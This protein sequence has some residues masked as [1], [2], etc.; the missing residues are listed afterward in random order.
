MYERNA[1]VIDRYFASIFGYDKNNNL[2]NNSSNYFEL[3]SSLEKYQK[4]SE[5][6]NNI[7]A[8]FEK[9][10]N[11]I[12][13]TQKLQ[14]VLNKRNLKYSET[15]KS[16][17]EGLEEDADTLKEKFEKIEEEINKNNQ[18]IKENSDK[19]IEEIIEFNEKSETRSDCGKER[20]IVENDYQKVL[21]TTTDIFNN[22]NKDKLKEIKA[23]VKSDNK[24]DAKQEIKEKILKNV[25]IYRRKKS[26]NI[27][28]FV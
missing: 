10:A 1:I 13:E 26:G 23:F 19:F 3:V 24:D 25:S 18:E 27:I 8:E 2:K 12:R 6:E 20:R 11:R 4:A 7:M 22:I 17:F 21:K 16:L 15:R 9:V 14:E 28:I 5:T